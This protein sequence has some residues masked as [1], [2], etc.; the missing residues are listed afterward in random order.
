[1]VNHLVKLPKSVKEFV[2]N[3]SLFDQDVSFDRFEDNWITGFF[4][5]G[6]QYPSK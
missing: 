4:I 6:K 5:Q 2:S 1:M 3:M